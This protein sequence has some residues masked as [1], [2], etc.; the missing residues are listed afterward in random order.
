MEYAVY[1]HD[2]AHIGCSVHV[3]PSSD[4]LCLLLYHF[5]MPDI[6]VFTQNNV[7]APSRLFHLLIPIWNIGIGD[8]ISSNR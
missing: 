3:F 5:F 6:V 7:L 4:V 1:V 2:V 8:A